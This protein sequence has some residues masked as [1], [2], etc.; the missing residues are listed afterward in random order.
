MT[1]THLVEYEPVEIRDGSTNDNYYGD[2]H[3]DVEGQSRALPGLTTFANKR[4]GDN[5]AYGRN[6]QLIKDR[7]QIEQNKARAMAD[8]WTV[9]F[10]QTQQRMQQQQTLEERRN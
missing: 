3:E 1:L 10:K 9:A 7:Q 4:P 8:E 2:G 6:I 5:D